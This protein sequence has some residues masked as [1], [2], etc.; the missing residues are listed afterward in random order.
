VIYPEAMAEKIGA[1]AKTCIGFGKSIADSLAQLKSVPHFPD[2]RF[3]ELFQQLEA[4]IIFIADIAAQLSSS[5]VSQVARHLQILEGKIYAMSVSFQAYASNLG[6]L[7]S[8]NK[9]RRLE[10]FAN[11]SNHL[12]QATTELDNWRSTFLQYLFLVTL[13][14][15]PLSTYSG[16]SKRMYEG[17]RALKKMSSLR[18]AIRSPNSYSSLR[19]SENSALEGSTKLLPDSQIWTGQL[20]DGRMAVAEEKAIDESVELPLLRQSVRRLMKILSQADPCRMSIL[21]GIGYHEIRTADQSCF[22][23]LYECPAGHINPRTLRNLLVEPGQS[24]AY[25]HSLTDRFEL[26]KQISKA[27]LFVHVTENVHKNLRPETVLIFEREGVED[28]KRFPYTIGNAYVVGLERLRQ[29]GPNSSRESDGQWNHD[30]YRH[31]TRQGINPP[32]VYS[33]RHD[34]YSLGVVL[35]EIAL[36]RPFIRWNGDAYYFESDTARYFLTSE[37]SMGEYSA[38]NASWSHKLKSP[39]EIQASLV[40]VAKKQV[41]RVMGSVFATVVTECLCCL[42]NDF[43]VHEKAEDEDQIDVGLKYIELVLEKLESIVV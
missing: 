2:S 15:D 22:Q 33:M 3:E 31:P 14:G 41:A 8:G 25:R 42:E 34:I 39:L 24:V 10:N 35:L 6:I 23:L 37:V 12:E 29:D 30:I 11:I 1:L 21:Q 28:S 43:Y 13:L 4:E 17:S 18:D 32:K 19:D 16:T 26:A 36:W 9:G 20:A 38:G 7:S 40:K 5:F 27:I